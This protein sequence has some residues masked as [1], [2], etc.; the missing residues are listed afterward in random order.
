M[1]MKHWLIHMLHMG[2]QV[3]LAFSNQGPLACHISLLDSHCSIHMAWSASQCFIHMFHMGDQVAL[4]SSHQRPSGFHISWLGSACSFQAPQMDHKE[5]L[6]FSH[7]G[8]SASQMAVFFSHCWI[9]LLHQVEGV[10][11]SGLDT[12]SSSVGMVSSAIGIISSSV[13]MVSSAIG[14]ISSSVGIPC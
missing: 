13:G 10:Q 9:R 11:F 1:W 14:I 7:Q 5:E 2:H 12:V 3:A 8:A 6:A 4:A